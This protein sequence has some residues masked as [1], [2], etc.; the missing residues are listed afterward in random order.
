MK[1]VILAAGYGNRMRPLTDDKHKTLL[2]IAGDTIIGRIMDTLSENGVNDIVVVTGYRDK[3]LKDYL[4][5]KY[6]R[7]AITYVHNERY[8]ETNNIF[9]MALAFNAIEIDSDIILI[10]SDLIYEPSVI[11]RIIHSQHD[12]AA[13]VDKFQHGMDGTVVRTRH[14][15]TAR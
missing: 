3:E 2:P 15:T 9:S 11:R 4:S 10:E 5:E 7:H 13:L 1:A 12:T 6:P 14:C 8:R